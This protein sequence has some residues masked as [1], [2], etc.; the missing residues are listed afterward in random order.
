MATVFDLT[1]DVFVRT[2]IVINK[3]NKISSYKS[4]LMD[5]H[6][7]SILRTG[8]N[9]IPNRF[10]IISKLNK[11]SKFTLKINVKYFNICL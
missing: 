1:L 3:I 6:I 9:L 10:F 5:K 4:R 7:R 11:N 2:N 8:K